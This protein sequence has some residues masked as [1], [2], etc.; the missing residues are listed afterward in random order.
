MQRTYKDRVLVFMR[1]KKRAHRLRVIFGLLGM[2]AAELHGDLSQAQRLAALA[3]FKAGDVCFLLATDLA[4]RGL[5]IPGVRTVVNASM[6][7]SLRQYIHRVGRT[8]RAG[9]R[10]LAV[11]LVG[12][13]ERRLLRR[14]VS[15]G[16]TNLRSRL[17]PSTVVNTLFARIEGLSDEISAVLRQEKEEKL[18]C[19][20]ARRA[21]CGGDAPRVLMCSPRSLSRRWSCARPR[22]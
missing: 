7:H 1:S 4:A 18:V 13:S 21:P 10:G 9:R 5:D 8:A 22:T 12:E 19:L 2:N 14:I 16:S 11:S 20:V 3:R 15:S 17:V 6:P